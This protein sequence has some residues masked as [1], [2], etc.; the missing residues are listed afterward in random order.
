MQILLRAIAPITCIVLAACST[1]F[2][3]AQPGG[4]PPLNARAAVRALS[5]GSSSVSTADEANND[6]V[7]CNPVCNTCKTLGGGLDAP[8]GN[9]DGPGDDNPVRH[10]ATKEYGFVADTNNSR[11]VEYTDSCSTVA[12]LNDSVKLSSTTIAYYP[13]GVAVSSDGTVAVTNLCPAPSCSGPG[14]IAFFARGSTEIT[15]IA[16]GLMSEYFFGGFDKHGDFYNDGLTSHGATVVGVVKRGSS[17][18]SPTKITSV[19]YPGG[20]AVARN[21]TIN[22]DDQQCSCIRIY[23]SSKQVGTVTL[24]DTV[25]A[26]TFA[27]TKSDS[28]IWVADKDKGEDYEFPYPAGGSSINVLTGFAEPIGIAVSPPSPP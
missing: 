25:D 20:V 1:P 10:A 28:D 12:I 7:I 3:S 23:K 27:F 26:I 24:T 2:G 15:S 8:M 11:V 4:A 16:T 9:G 18:D 22:I 14:N 19:G 21:G 5:T 13:V 6:L 17:I